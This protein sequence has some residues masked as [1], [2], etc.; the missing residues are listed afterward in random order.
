MKKFLVLIMKCRQQNWFLSVLLQCKLFFPAPAS[1]L[2]IQFNSQTGRTVL[3]A[4]FAQ[5]LTSPTLLQ[6]S[7]SSG[8]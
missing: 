6:A 4:V 1:V 7:P 5:A 2:K 8:S 3:N